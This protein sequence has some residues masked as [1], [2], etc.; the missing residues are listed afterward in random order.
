MWYRILNPELTINL[1]LI[2]P[3]ICFLSLLFFGFLRSV[4]LTFAKGFVW[5][6]LV[7]GSHFVWLAVLLA[8][9]SHA[10]WIFAFGGYALIVVY[11]SL[12]SGVWFYVTQRLLGRCRGKHTRLERPV[13]FLLSTIIYYYFIENWSLFIL[14][15]AEGYPF[16]NPLIPFAHYRPIL[17]LVAKI[18]A[19][20]CWVTFGSALVL[21]P[22][23]PGDVKFVYLPPVCGPQDNAGA[24]GQRVYHALAK[25]NV[26]S[27]GIPTIIV[28]PE[29]FYPFSL[30]LHQEQEALWTSVIPDDVHM[31]VGSQLTLKSLYGVKFY[32]A[33]YLLNNGLIKKNYVKR[34]CTPFVE[35]IP[36]L[37]RRVT[38]LRDIFLQNSDEFSRGRQPI[39]DGVFDIGGNLQF[40]P[41]ICSEFFFKTTSGQLWDVCRKKNT[42]KTAILFL[43]NDSW[44]VEYFKQILKATTSIKAAYL[45]LPIV[46]VGHTHGK[47]YQ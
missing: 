39:R 37:W 1:V 2:T 23:T 42:R 14:G 27:G 26:S 28:T 25:L 5:G 22:L 47:W 7:F 13:G 11:F 29:T 24:A 3:L 34:H 4:R 21:H 17:W 6:L 40:I 12:T 10:P 9:K 44:F 20:V 38:P 41:Q 8:T 19:L 32:Q 35:K 31:V 15:R 16:L 46:Y 33:A 36:R 30:N 45:G 18:G 43:V